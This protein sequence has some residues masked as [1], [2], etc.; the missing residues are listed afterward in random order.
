MLEYLGC[1]QYFTIRNNFGMNSVIYY[2]FLLIRV[3]FIF[4]FHMQR[5]IYLTKTQHDTVF[6]VVIV[7]FWR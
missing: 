4:L 1:F 6:S 5:V 7:C 2:L 3:V